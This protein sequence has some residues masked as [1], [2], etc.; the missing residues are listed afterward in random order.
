MLWN[1][2][3]L[4]TRRDVAMLGVVHRAALKKGHSHFQQFFAV[5]EEQATHWTREAARRE[6]HGKQLKGLNSKVWFQMQERILA[7]MQQSHFLVLTEI[8][9]NWFSQVKH[10]FLATSQVV[11]VF[12][13]WDAIHDG[14]E[15]AILWATATATRLEK[16][17][18]FYTF[19][20]SEC[21]RK[22]WRRNLRELFECGPGKLGKGMIGTCRKTGHSSSIGSDPPVNAPGRAQARALVIPLRVLQSTPVCCIGESS[23]PFVFDST[24]FA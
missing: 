18:I 15:L 23:C 11:H 5:K 6:R 1:M 21:R 22:W 13:Q 9:P 7:G 20:E 19:P 10:R 4:A 8:N 14:H 2:A 24:F 16:A 12:G 17:E 3:P